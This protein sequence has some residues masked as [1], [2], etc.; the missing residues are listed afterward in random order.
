MIPDADLYGRRVESF[1]YDLLDV[2]N[3]KLDVL[4]VSTAV[5]GSIDLS[6]QATAQGSGSAT[7][8][9]KTPI[10]WLQHRVRVWY[11][12]ASGR[13]VALLTAIPKV[14]GTTYGPSSA[15]QQVQLFDCTEAVD[16]DRYGTSFALPAGTN[17]IAAAT[18]VIAS[19]GEPGAV[20]EP[21]SKTL[22]AP[23]SWDS[24]ATKLRIVNDLLDA[25]GYFALYADGMG[26]LRGV[27]WTDPRSRPVRWR[28]AGD[29][30][31]LYTPDFTVTD[32][33]SDIPNKVTGTSRALDDGT[34]WT[35]TA[36]DTDPASDYSFVN[37]GR[38]VA[39]DP[40]TDVDAASPAVLQQLV[41]RRLTESQ[42][43]QGTYS[44]RH[45]WLPFGLND[46]V[47]ATFPRRNETVLGSVQRQTYTLSP[48]GLVRSE[49]VKVA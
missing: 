21:S 36:L 16:G 2:R 22:A 13:E 47:Q 43:V 35:F 37:R 34:T 42:Q 11:L 3:N 19:T 31:N 49:L 32:N 45:P 5:T 23:M 38:W 40:M 41:S 1:R 30:S 7:I 44:I 48:G 17:I 28:F 12:T 4:Q 39:G 18:D 26:R 8:T 6:T 29:A 10:N 46:V 14:P 33:R 20:L 24:T 25:A 27:P 15:T 9:P